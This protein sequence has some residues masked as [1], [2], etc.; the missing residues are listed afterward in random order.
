MTIRLARF[1]FSV[2]LPSLLVTPLLAQI[3]AGSVLW[4]D[5]DDPATIFDEGGMNPNGFGFTGQVQEWHDKSD[6]GY[7]L[8]AGSVTSR[9]NDTTPEYTTGV[10]NGLATVRFHD[11]DGLAATSTSPTAGPGLATGNDSRH[12]FFA[13]IPTTNV[14]GINDCC[15]EGVNAYLVYGGL[16]GSTWNN[17]FIY[18]NPGTDNNLYGNYFAGRNN[19]INFSENDIYDLTNPPGSPTIIEFSYDGSV[20]TFHHDGML[21]GSAAPH[22][23]TLNTGLAY[24]R[25]GREPDQ[26]S[27]WDQLELI[28]FSGVLD[29]QTRNVV[30]S[31]LSTKWGIAS[32]YTDV[33]D[34]TSFT[35][36]VDGAADWANTSNWTP[37]FGGTDPVGGPGANQDVVFGDVITAGRTVFKDS[38]ATVRSI[39]FDNANT[40]NIAGVGGMTLD[41]GSNPNA[42]I[43]V[44]QGSHQFQTQVALNHDTNVD[45]AASATLVFNNQLSL[46]GNTLTKTGTGT[47]T[48]NNAL[49]GG[50]GNVNCQTGTCNG[51]GTIGGSL[52]NGAIVAPGAEGGVSVV[53]EPTTLL[54]LAL[55]IGIA[56][57]RRTEGRSLVS[58]KMGPS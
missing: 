14:H 52:V 26:A 27:D 58:R 18:D 50:G 13:G 29:E 35:W 3:P 17:L 16:T 56:V 4:L 8:A 51:T 7:V 37:A 24:I 54:L 11:L 34:P 28:V 47:L 22:N 36:N 41:Q 48:I 19:D 12:V 53:P 1:L 20:G 9:G 25:V 55:G 38:P 46:N 42:A 39:Q 10:Q 15:N 40:Y 45:I 5:A 21:D 30:G 33:S 31:Y 32:S 6:S 43:T 57:A 44:V 2:L 49:N 23:G